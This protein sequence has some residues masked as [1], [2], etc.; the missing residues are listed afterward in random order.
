MLKRIYSLDIML[1]D[2][3]AAKIQLIRY[4]LIESPF[5]NFFLGII[6]ILFIKNISVILQKNV[7]NF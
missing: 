2:F 7:E 4:Q 6:N 3:G 1:N 5:F